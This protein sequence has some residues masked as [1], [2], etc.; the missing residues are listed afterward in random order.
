MSGSREERA[1]LGTSGLPRDYFKWVPEIRTWSSRVD[2][3]VGSGS[4]WLSGFDLAPPP[5]IVQEHLESPA[6]GLVVVGS[7][8]YKP[9]V[10]GVCFTSS[11]WKHQPVPTEVRSPA[12]W[13]RERL[14]IG[15]GWYSETAESFKWQGGWKG[16]R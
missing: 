9:G 8:A 15:S 16:H 2:S 7:L 12:E 3:E 10:D 1:A 14:R 4:Y 6:L 5:S 13:E 11:T